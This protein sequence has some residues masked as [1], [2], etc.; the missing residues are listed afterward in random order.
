[1][2]AEHV[3]RSFAAASLVWLCATV[4]RP[5]DRVS[6]RLQHAIPV[7]FTSVRT[8]IALWYLPSWRVMPQKGL[9]SVYIQAFGE[10]FDA[11]IG[12]DWRALNKTSEDSSEA[13]SCDEGGETGVGGDT[14]TQP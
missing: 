13:G 4:L 6:G 14:D 12:S 10:Q 9:G 8:R 1:M 5:L 11:L 3:A 7:S 2:A